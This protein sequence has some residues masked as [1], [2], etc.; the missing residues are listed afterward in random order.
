MPAPQVSDPRADSGPRDKAE[1]VV[2]NRDGRKA[3]YRGLEKR[4]RRRAVKRG[5]F[6]VHI[7]GG[8]TPATTQAR[9]MV[10]P[11]LLLGVEAPAVIPMIRAS[12]SQ[13]DSTTSVAFTA[14]W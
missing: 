7:A 10:S 8:S 11:T 12:P 14:G 13:S 5:C 2:A 9:T 3:G 6:A 4:H 1:L